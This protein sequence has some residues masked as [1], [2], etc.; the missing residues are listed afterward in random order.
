[1]YTGMQYKRRLWVHASCITRS[2]VVINRTKYKVI[3]RL[4][5]T[6]VPRLS[7]FSLSYKK[8]GT[9][10]VASSHRHDHMKM[11]VRLAFLSQVFNYFYT[12]RINLYFN[13]ILRHLNTPAILPEDIAWLLSSCD[14]PAIVLGVMWC[15]RI[16][17]I[18]WHLIGDS[19][20]FVFDG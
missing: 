12:G 20:D 8:E 18:I 17:C 4:V 6:Q 9:I 14:Q 1:M 3:Y 19:R 15:V 13:L 5:S 16:W 10:Q 11:K 2:N 7:S